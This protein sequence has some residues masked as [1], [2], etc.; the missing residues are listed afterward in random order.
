MIQVQLDFF[1]TPEEQ[2]LHTLKKFVEEVKI[3]N[4]KVR[5]KLFCEHGN[6]RKLLLEL[7]ERLKIIEKYI[8]KT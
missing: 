8:C 4:D 5:R 6:D 1:H 7:D 3:S 2:E